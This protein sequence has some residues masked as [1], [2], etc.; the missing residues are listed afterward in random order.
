MPPKRK[1]SGAAASVDSEPPPA[2]ATAVASAAPIR[3]S[4]RLAR[5]VAPA[6]RT[7]VMSTSQSIRAF[8]DD[9][10]ASL[11]ALDAALGSKAAV[12]LLRRGGA[13]DWADAV[14]P[15]ADLAVERA[16][17]DAPIGQLAV[18]GTEGPAS[19]RAS[20]DAGRDAEARPIGLLPAPGEARGDPARASKREASASKTAARDAEVA[21][22]TTTRAKVS[23]TKTKTTERPASARH[24]VLPTATAAS[25]ERAGALAKAE[26]A[27]PLRCLR[28]RD[29]V[30]TEGLASRKRRR[31]Y[32]NGDDVFRVPA[33]SR[34]DEDARTDRSD[35]RGAESD[36]PRASCSGAVTTPVTTPKRLV[37][38]VDVLVSVGIHNP[39]RPAMVLEEFLCAGADSLA[40]LKDRVTCAADEQAVEAGLPP[41]ERRG[42]FFVEGV[43]HEDA[44]DAFEEEDARDAD[45]TERE[46]LFP[47]SYAAPVAAHHASVIKELGAGAHRRFTAPG[48]RAFVAE[49][50]MAAREAAVAEALATRA[51]DAAARARAEGARRRARRRRG[52]AP[53]AASALRGGRFV[54]G[55]ARGRAARRAWQTVLSAAPRR[56]RPRGDDPRRAP[57]ARRRRAG[58]VGV[59]SARLRGA[60]VPPEVLDVLDFRGGGGDAARRAGAVLAVLLLRELLR[61]PAREGGRHGRVRGVREVRV[62]PRVEGRGEESPEE[63]RA[64]RTRAEASRT[65]VD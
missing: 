29:A 8:A 48:E 20:P 37:P 4:V 47:A 21:P 2:T 44:R 34:A 38:G 24:D 27:A 26:A 10:R 45:G 41:R 46:N 51:G 62:L 59:P 36:A 58:R 56:L 11:A 53:P 35:D 12:A 60:R 6:P 28:Q 3:A 52:G 31:R 14:I 15:S 30:K 19:G 63:R 57:G 5:V 40:A 55:V 23:R 1:P 25:L 17:L 49:A 39:A 61:V 42:F 54:R 33:D 13:L 43:F 18:T 50:A 22:A 64:Q 16:M 32:K 65:R 9:A 7:G